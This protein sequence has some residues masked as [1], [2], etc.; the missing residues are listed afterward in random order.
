[1]LSSFLRPR[2]HADLR[3]FP[4][5]RSS[6]LCGSRS[7]AEGQS[8]SRRLQLFKARQ[9]LQSRQRTRKW[10]LGRG[11]S[12]SHPLGRRFRDGCIAP[13]RS[14]EHTSELQSREKLVC[15]L[16]LEKKN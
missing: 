11:C 4:T 16:L 9:R 10:R 12:H 13:G 15:R 5:R 3:S 2:A 1:S 8:Q 6:D 14:E 7:R